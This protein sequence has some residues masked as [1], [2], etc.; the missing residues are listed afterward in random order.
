MKASRQPRF[1]SNNFNLCLAPGVKVV[2]HVATDNY[3]GGKEAAKAMIEALGEAGGGIALLDYKEVESCIQR[4]KGFKEA[5]AAYNRG[6]SSG[7]I[8][9][10]AEL[11]GHG[12]KDRGYRA[13]A[14]ALQA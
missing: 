14:D 4:V 2:C 3:G 9:I 6:R 8:E 7:K 11:D 12:D 5:L 1:A 10:I 13:A